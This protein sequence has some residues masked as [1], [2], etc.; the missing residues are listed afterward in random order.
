[1]AGADDGSRHGLISPDQP[2]RLVE[3]GGQPVEQQASPNRADGNPRMTST[4][5]TFQKSGQQAGETDEQRYDVKHVPHT[6]PL[7]AHTERPPARPEGRADAARPLW[8]PHPPP[9][10]SPG[11][12]MRP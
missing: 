11:T 9:R 1:M 4:T 3:H 8:T 5:G 6:H 12:I 2:F 7:C 10:Q